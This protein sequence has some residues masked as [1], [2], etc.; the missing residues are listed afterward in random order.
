MKGFIIRFQA[1]V[2][3][4]VLCLACNSPEEK[5]DPGVFTISP[6]KAQVDPTPQTVSF[7]ITCDMPWTASVSPSDWATLKTSSG[8]GNGTIKVDV[9]LNEGN[10]NRSA[11]LTVK[12]GNTTKTA[13]I[14][15]YLNDMIQPSM[16]DIAMECNGGQINYDITAKV[17]YEQSLLGNPDWARIAP[18][19]KAQSTKSFVLEVDPNLSSEPRETAI[20]IKDKS[21]KLQSVVPVRQGSR[22]LSALSKSSVGVYNYDGKGA[23]FATE[24]YGRQILFT[25][26]TSSQSWC[27]LDPATQSYFELVDVPSQLKI[28]ELFELKVN[29]NITRNFESRGTHK[30]FAAKQEGGLA[31]IFALDGYCVIINR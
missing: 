18:Y 15:Q 14:V 4:A 12:A 21:S 19:S 1:Y 20:V 7:S 22:D 29:Q 13:E 28:N 10:A 27:F 3:A 2:L 16:A 24:R 5:T 26:G 9:A 17:D 6:A 31:W 23:D 25:D 11:T 30:F 8:N